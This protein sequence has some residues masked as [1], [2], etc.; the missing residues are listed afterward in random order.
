MPTAAYS[1]LEFCRAH[2]FSRAHFYN[3]VKRGQG[4]KIMFAGNR[5][6]ISEEAAA[7]WRQRMESAAEHRAAVTGGR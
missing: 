4:P 7:A 2:R 5:R 1:I 3:L 6:L